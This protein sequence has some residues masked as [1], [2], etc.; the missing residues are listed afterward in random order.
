MCG[1]SLIRQCSFDEKNN[2]LDYYRLFKKV[3]STLKKTS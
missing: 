3:L 1:S 2:K